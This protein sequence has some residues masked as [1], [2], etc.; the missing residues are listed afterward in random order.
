MD[1]ST[2]QFRDSGIPS[3]AGGPN[4]LGTGLPAL[5]GAQ[6][7]IILVVDCNGHAP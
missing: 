3:K 6:M 2:T 5:R 7:P 1:Y 4:V